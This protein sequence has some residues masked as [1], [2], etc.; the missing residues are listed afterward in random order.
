MPNFQL[1]SG[2]SVELHVAG[3][4][5]AGQFVPALPNVNPLTHAFDAPTWATSDATKTQL[6]PSPDGNTCSI[7]G[8]ALGVG[9]TITVTAGLLTQTFLIDVVSNVPLS[10][11]INPNPPVQNAGDIDVRQLSAGGRYLG[12]GF[13]SPPNN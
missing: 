10:L 12:I 2:Q 4:N 3:V 8:K 6:E 5:G 13:A 9:T 1:V 7:L 11:V